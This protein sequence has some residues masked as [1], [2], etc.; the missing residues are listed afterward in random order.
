ML[1]VAFTAGAIAQA[2]EYNYATGHVQGRNHVGG[3]IGSVSGEAVQVRNSY[4]RGQVN[5]DSHVGGFAGSNMAQI[6]NCYST[7]EVIGHAYVG[8]FVGS[9]EGTVL[10]AYWDTQ[11][12]GQTISAGGEGR[13]TSDMT[14]PYG[15]NTF[16][17]WDFA[18]IWQHDLSPIENDG[19]PMI[20][21]SDV[22]LLT[23]RVDPPGAGNVSGTGYYMSNL[24]V[25]VIAS[26]NSGFGFTGWYMNG[27]LLSEQPSYP[28]AVN[29]N[30]TMVARFEPIPVNV[31]TVIAPADITV[32][33]N[34]ANTRFWVEITNPQQMVYD[35]LLIN[36]MGQSIQNQRIDT[37]LE[38]KV[39]FDVGQMK[40]GIYLVVVHNHAGVW[41]SKI[42]IQ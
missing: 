36:L 27:V 38:K 28:V 12:S 20:L 22:F 32:F 41:T 16:A 34:P 42:F 29:N 10:G 11:T 40:P 14:H 15:A 6:E 5:G 37:S 1:Q 4:A 18:N 24:T 23:L 17:G 21:A 19:Y 26:P 3:L 35:I 33:P 2:V 31:P 8:G 39:A 7:G 30:T 13:T 25:E 9:G